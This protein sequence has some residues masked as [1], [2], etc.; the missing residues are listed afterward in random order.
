M[1]LKTQLTMLFVDT[2]PNEFNDQT[3]EIATEVTVSKYVFL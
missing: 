2:A 3:H 1:S